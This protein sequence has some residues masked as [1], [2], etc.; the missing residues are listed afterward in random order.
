MFNKQKKN[1]KEDMV[2]APAP[3]PPEETSGED[4]KSSK[5]TG[6]S[7]EANVFVKVPPSVL[8]SDLTVKGNLLTG[9]HCR[10]CN[11]Y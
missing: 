3:T 1:E 4:S 10:I 5:S 8:S 6:S 7:S 9:S 2:V 11:Q